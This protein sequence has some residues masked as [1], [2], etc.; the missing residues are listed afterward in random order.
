[1]FRT[2]I[3]EVDRLIPRR[4]IASALAQ[5][6]KFSPMTY[7][8]STLSLEDRECFQRVRNYVAPI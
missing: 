8:F 1:M 7:G 5:I 3:P 2:E 6:G 4:R